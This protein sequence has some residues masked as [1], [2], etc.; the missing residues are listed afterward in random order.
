LKVERVILFGATGLVGGELLKELLK[1]SFFKKVIVVTR[2]KLNFN[3]PK[4]KNKQ[5]NFSNAN[6]IQNC[7]KGGTVVFSTIGTTSSKVNGEKNEYRKVDFCITRNIGIACRDQN[8]KKFLVVSS[9]G[10]DPSS[11]NFYLSLK[12]QIEEELLR[13]NLK[14]IVIFQPSLL[15]GKRREFRL[16]EKIAQSIMPLFSFFLPRNVRPVKASLVALTMIHYSKSQ[17]IG[18][19]IVT[20]SKILSFKNAL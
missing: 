9:S 16:G 14:T 19:N 3:H 20:N 17:F 1:D 13:L 5:I 8:I 7:I 15:I 10:A 18:N 6:E 11:S 2:S 12:G 4:L